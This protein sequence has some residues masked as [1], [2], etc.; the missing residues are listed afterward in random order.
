MELLKKLRDCQIFRRI[1]LYDSVDDADGVDPLV[2]EIRDERQF[3]PWRNRDKRRHVCDWLS[4][5]IRATFRFRPFPIQG[6]KKT[7]L[8]VIDFSF[9][10]FLLFFLDV[11]TF[12]FFSF[13]S[14]AFFC[15][16]EL[17]FFFTPIL[18]PKVN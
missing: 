14:H 1:I 16:S 18:S 12:L 11:G 5:L 8:F 9:F 6:K 7:F 2:H 17:F 13:F 15:T 10:S 4:Y 3:I